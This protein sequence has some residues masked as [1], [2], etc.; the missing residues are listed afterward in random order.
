M[1][2]LILGKNPPVKSASLRARFAI[3]GTRLIYLQSL[4]QFIESMVDAPTEKQAFEP[5]SGGNQNKSLPTGSEQIEA[6]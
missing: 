2:A 3:R 4:L 1:N 6:K 5:A